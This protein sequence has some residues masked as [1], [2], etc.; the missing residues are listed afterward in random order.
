MSPDDLFTAV[1]VPGKCIPHI[2]EFVRI[3]RKLTNQWSKDYKNDLIFYLLPLD[4]DA[5][6][7][8][9]KYKYM[10]VMTRCVTAKWF[11]TNEE[12]RNIPF[13]ETNLGK[14]FYI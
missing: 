11:V 12:M 14:L 5:E 4:E 8:Y 2:R 9:I 10:G 3:I 7:I 6:I 1:H 13:I